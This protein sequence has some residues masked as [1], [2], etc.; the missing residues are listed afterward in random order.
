MGKVQ[1]W[2]LIG[3]QLEKI[4]WLQE[5]NLQTQ[6][7]ERKSYNFMDQKVSKLEFK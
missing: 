6:F 2:K 1:T 4:Q 5:G 3:W 7:S